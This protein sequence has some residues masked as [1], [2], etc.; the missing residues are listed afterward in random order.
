[1]SAEVA[2]AIRQTRRTL[3]EKT[4]VPGWP[5]DE[6]ECCILYALPEHDLSASEPAPLY[7]G[8][9]AVLGAV[10]GTE[11]LS[12]WNDRQ[13]D[14]GAVLGMTLEALIAELCKATP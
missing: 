2:E 4:W 8:C 3:A 1:V 7:E 14:V 5:K 10:A 11:S 12:I 13:T 6:N 9:K